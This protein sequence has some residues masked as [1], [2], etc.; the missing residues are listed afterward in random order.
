M[1]PASLV[2]VVVMSV[3]VVVAVTASGDPSPWQAVFWTYGV[4]W[5][6]HAW[7]VPVVGILSQGVHTECREETSSILS[8]QREIERRKRGRKQARGRNTVRPQ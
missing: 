2:L 6:V 4:S 3:L 1:L 5:D 8:R 7:P